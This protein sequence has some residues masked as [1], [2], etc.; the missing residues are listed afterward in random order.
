MLDG[1]KLKMIELKLENPNL[2]NPELADMIGVTRQA[3][4]EWWKQGR[5]Q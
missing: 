1:R 2:T 5:C 3:I 4:W